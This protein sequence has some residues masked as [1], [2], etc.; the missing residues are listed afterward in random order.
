MP[1]I[2]GRSGGADEAVLE[3]ETGFVVDSPTD[4]TA[5]KQALEQLLVDSETRK[6]MGR[7]S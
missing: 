2:A 3:G 6:E 4:F 1:Q 5:V 7:N